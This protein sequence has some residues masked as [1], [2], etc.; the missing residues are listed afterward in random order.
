MERTVKAKKKHTISVLVLQ[1]VLLLGISGCFIINVNLTPESQP[2]EEQVIAGKGK[3]KIVMVDITGMITTEESGTLLGASRERGM[4]AVVREQLDR[5]RSDKRVKA[6]VLRINS[7]GGS[8][9]ASDT[10]YHEINKF[11]DETGVKV[12]AHFTDTA[13]SGAYYL[14]LAADRI[15]AQPTTI[16]GSIGV[17]MLR[18]DATGLMQKIGVRATQISSGPEKAMGSPFQEMSA[19]ERKIFQSMIDSLFDRFFKL[20]VKERNLAPERARQFADGRIYTAA[21]A[22]EAGLIDDIG[23]LQ[24]SFTDAK[25]LANIEKAVIVAYARPGEYRPNIYSLNMNLFNVSLG[26]LAGPGVK[27][28]YLWMP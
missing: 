2:L 19:E 22:K 11:R 7:P 10:L 27:F 28:T 6:L 18:V 14:A 13:A 12:V 3:D 17:T 1:A 4:V 9:T 24:D 15:I 5:A 16:T 23:Y 26:D 8:V 21:E 20:V 25:K